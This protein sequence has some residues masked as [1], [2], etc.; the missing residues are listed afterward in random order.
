MDKKYGLNFSVLFFKKAKKL[1]KKNQDFKNKLHK[2][3]DVLACDPFHSS[4]KTH[5]V[6]TKLYGRAYSSWI[7]EN[8]RL[9]WDFNA[10]A[11][12][13]LDVLDIGGHSGSKKIYK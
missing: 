6:E 1:L 2:A 13:I 12:V 4:L 11:A 8:I 5:K 10:E 7:T 3:I 9:I